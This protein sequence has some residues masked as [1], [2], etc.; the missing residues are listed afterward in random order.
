M[1]ETELAEIVED[2]TK[3]IQDLED[4]KT[5]LIEMQE[6][7]RGMIT[8]VKMWFEQEKSQRNE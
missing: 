5:H 2:L 3:Q 6:E 7:T 4:L 1:S 8:G